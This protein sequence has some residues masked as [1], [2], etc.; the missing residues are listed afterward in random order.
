MPAYVL[1]PKWR[2]GIYDKYWMGRKRNRPRIEDLIRI[3]VH[4]RIVN[5]D[6][7]PLFDCDGTRFD[8]VDETDDDGN[9][10]LVVY[11][12]GSRTDIKFEIVEKRMYHIQG[13]SYSRFYACAGAKLVDHLYIDLLRRKIGDRHTLG[14]IYTSSSVRGT[15]QEAGWRGPQQVK[16]A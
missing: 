7:R 6:N 16:K 12:N 5:R 2:P 1:L 9:Q 4:K 10:F 8:F 3:N 15:K 14:A 13:G 11:V